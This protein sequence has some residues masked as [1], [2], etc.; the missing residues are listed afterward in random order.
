VKIGQVW[1]NGGDVVRS[2]W[3]PA[4]PVSRSADG[5]RFGTGNYV[6]KVVVREYDDFGKKVKVVGEKL[7]SNR[8]KIVDFATPKQ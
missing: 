2:Q 7:E 3:F 8:E 1:A 4:V 5:K 6:V